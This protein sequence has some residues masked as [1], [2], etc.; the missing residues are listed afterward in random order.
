MLVSVG[1]RF[2]DKHSSGSIAPWI[3]NFGTLVILWER[4]VAC[5]CL[6]FHL[7]VYFSFSPVRRFL[8]IILSRLVDELPLCVR[9]RV[10]MWGWRCCRYMISCSLVQQKYQYL[11]LFSLCAEV[12]AHHCSFSP[13][14]SNLWRKY[15]QNKCIHKAYSEIFVL[16]QN[17]LKYL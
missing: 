5:P 11:S 3:L 2:A 14:F 9:V 16:R 17:Y 1:T 10:C 8:E 7:V 13:E 6:F 4:E 12:L 15:D